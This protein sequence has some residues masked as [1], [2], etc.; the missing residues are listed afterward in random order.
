MLTGE[1]LGGTGWV[2]QLPQG[3]QNTG[4]SFFRALLSPFGVSF[5]Q[6]ANIEHHT[7]EFFYVHGFFVPNG[8]TAIGLS[9]VSAAAN[10]LP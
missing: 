8:Q 9:V 5:Q 10:L 4:E 7:F 1:D 3:L 2:L 6:L